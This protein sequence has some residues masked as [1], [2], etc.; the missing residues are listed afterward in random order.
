MGSL[1]L[2]KAGVGSAMN[3]TTRMVG[4]ALGVAVVG[5][6]TAST[7]VQSMSRSLARAPGFPALLAAAAPSSVGAATQ[8]VA[9]LGPRGAA[10]AHV[11]RTAF[12]HGASQGLGVG[13]GFVLAG[14]VV[15]LLFLPSR[16]V[17]RT[18]TVGIPTAGEPASKVA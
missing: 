6:V 7:Y 5:S 17:S 14:A 1:P 8:L 16:G 10:L 18:Q 12:V 4:G 3:D 11:A 9:R 2:A 15:V 13:L